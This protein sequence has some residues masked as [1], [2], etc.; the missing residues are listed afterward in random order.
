[1]YKIII[2]GFSHNGT[3]ILK[4]II[5]HID[6]VYEV[7]NEA[8]GINKYIIDNAKKC[9]NKDTILIKT[10]QGRLQ[11]DFFND[12][13]YNDYIKIFII[14]NPVYVFSSL[15]KRSNYNIWDSHSIEKYIEIA[16]KFIELQNDNRLNK[17]IFLIKYEDLFENNY[18]NL[19]D[20]I[21]K[22][23]FLNFN[24]KIYNNKLYKNYV[25]ENHTIVPENEPPSQINGIKCINHHMYRTF[26]INQEF[27]NMNH[28]NKIDL[29]DKQK[30]IIKN[31][32]TIKILY[33]DIN[34]LI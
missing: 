4:S 25:N 8:A 15:N 31:N 2:Y 14:R 23:K 3:S 20:I 28:I 13:Q 1:M 30:K 16:N 34:D 22:I 27:K 9:K 11:C 24:E 5:G 7:I 32:P 10:T 33:P 19:T 17:S 26:Q 18:Q 29:T 12:I 6:N 21:K